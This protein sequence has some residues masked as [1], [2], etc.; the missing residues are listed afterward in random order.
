MNNKKK[1]ILISSL[2]FILG[3]VSLYLVFYFFP[4][5]EQKVIIN[6]QEKEITVTDKG[7]ADAV[8]KIY[9]TVVIVE[10][11]KKDV[12]ISSGTG[13]VYKKANGKAYI[14]TN[15]HVVAGA[16]TITVTFTSKEKQKVELVGSDEYYDLAVMSVPENK[17]NSIAELGSSLDLR[18]GDTVFAV[19]APLSNEYSWTVTRGIVSGK[20][21]LVPVSVNNSS[22]MSDYIMRVIQTDASINSGNSGG[23]LSNSNGEVV[24]ITSLKLVSSGIEGMGFAIPIEDAISFANIVEK[25]EKIVRPSIGVSISDI[26]P[27][28]I[29]NPTPNNKFVSEGAEVIETIEGYPAAKA[30]IKKGDVIIQINTNKIDSVASL[31]YYL[32][33]YSVGDTI[34]VKINRSGKEIDLK[35]TLTT[36]Q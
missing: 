23:P 16:D 5:I 31:K 30:G 18:L 26:Q 17:I 14:L 25:G 1:T 32:Y 28:S 22:L 7:I 4:N 11:Y 20:D 9:N 8:D 21:R 27:I 10:N 2:T 33:K 29:F 36:P 19:G 13:F 12:K 34:T 24:G 35:V 15:N 3:V 6:K